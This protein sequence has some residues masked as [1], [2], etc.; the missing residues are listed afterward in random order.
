MSAGRSQEK[1][2]S[3]AIQAERIEDAR[4]AELE[5]IARGLDAD[6]DGDPDNDGF[7]RD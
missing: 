2:E 5:E 3:A 7:R 4:N 1:A 6:N